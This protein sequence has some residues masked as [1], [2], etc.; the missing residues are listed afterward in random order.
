MQNW[1]LTLL[2]LAVPTYQP[3]SFG[4]DKTSPSCILI[5]TP[6]SHVLRMS[7]AGFIARRMN[8]PDKTGILASQQSVWPG[9]AEAQARLSSPAETTVSE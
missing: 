7:L 9:S 4:D 8:N 1:C 2:V 5:L 3:I 6:D